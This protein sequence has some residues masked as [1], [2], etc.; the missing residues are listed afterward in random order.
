MI[1]AYEQL[2][3]DMQNTVHFYYTTHYKL[4]LPCTFKFKKFLL[5]VSYN[6]MLEMQKK[7]FSLTLPDVAEHNILYMEVLGTGICQTLP[8]T[9]LR[10]PVLPVI[11]GTYPA[12]H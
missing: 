12:H 1:F 7:S 10:Y 9:T 8:G 3:T 6:I 5:D 2:S 11:P 4:Q